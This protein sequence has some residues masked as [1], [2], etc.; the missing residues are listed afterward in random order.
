MTPYSDIFLR[1][2]LPCCP[3]G[4]FLLDK[5]LS[6]PKIGSPKRRAILDF[7]PIY[8]AII[9]Y[10]CYIVCILINNANLKRYTRRRFGGRQPLCG[11]G[12]TSMISVTSIPAP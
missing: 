1:R 10:K 6:A 8:L 3:G 4:K 2:L 9:S 11:N 12:V 7:G 5:T